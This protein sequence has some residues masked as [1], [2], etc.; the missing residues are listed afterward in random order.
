MCECELLIVPILIPISLV[1]CI[2]VYVL[3]SDIIKER[4]D[5]LCWVDPK[6]FKDFVT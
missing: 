2:Q 3:R 6:N 4:V 1:C 5:V